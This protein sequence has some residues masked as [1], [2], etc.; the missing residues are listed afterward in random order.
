[1]PSASEAC[2]VDRPA[3]EFERALLSDNLDVLQSLPTLRIASTLA[4]LR[5]AWS[6]RIRRIASAATASDRSKPDNTCCK[7]GSNSAADFRAISPLPRPEALFRQNVWQSGAR[8]RVL[9]Y[10]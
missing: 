4:C 10:G 6:M 9:K 3:K 5:R 1:M 2:G 7:K 8:K